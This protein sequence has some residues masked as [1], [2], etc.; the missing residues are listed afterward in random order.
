M[1]KNTD[2]PDT[3]NTEHQYAVIDARQTDLEIKMMDLENSVAELNAVIIRQAGEIDTLRA[4]HQRLL[5][6][7]HTLEE[8][9]G[10]IDPNET[11][12]HY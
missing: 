6:Q 12:P 8:R 5:I 1:N 7:L 11:P 10:Q 3:G 9:G 4:A 2:N